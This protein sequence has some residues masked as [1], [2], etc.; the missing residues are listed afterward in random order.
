[1][2]VATGIVDRAAIELEG[3][4]TSIILSPISA[5]VAR[6][7]PSGVEAKTIRI[8]CANRW[9]NS[10]RKKE[11]STPGR[12]PSNCCILRRSCVGFRSPSSSPV[13]NCCWRRHSE[14]VVRLMSCSFR[15]A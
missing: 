12:S 15:A 6:A 7:V 3:L 11:G 10:S 9:W 8:A 2:C 14:T 1:M 4:E 5:S 13:S